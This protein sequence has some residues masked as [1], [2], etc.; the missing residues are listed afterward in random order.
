MP[1]GGDDSCS[2]EGE[3]LPQQS[4]GLMGKGFLFSAKTVTRKPQRESNAYLGYRRA[5]DGNGNP[6]RCALLYK[7][8]T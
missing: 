3:S 4:E 8:G 2:R 6:F 5:V 7:H 1:S